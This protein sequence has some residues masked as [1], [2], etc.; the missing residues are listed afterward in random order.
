VDVLLKS[1]KSEVDEKI[2]R[3]GAALL[4]PLWKT[5]TTPF[6]MQDASKWENF[7]RWMQTNG[8]LGS[9]VQAADAFSNRFMG[10]N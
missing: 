6:G 2:E 5:D 10:G 8:L 4:A 3:P 7:V 1:T 9:Q